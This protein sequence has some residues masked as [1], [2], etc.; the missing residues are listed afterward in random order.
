M[1]LPNFETAR[2]VLR[3]RA[4]AD[5]EACLAMDRE[6]GVTRFVVGPWH[7][8]LA[9]RALIERRTLGP[10]GDGLGYWVIAPRDEP[11]GFLGWV[12]L[13]AEDAIGPEVE[14]GWRLRR[15]AWG[16]GFAT[17]AARPV[18]AHGINSVGLVRVIADI[19]PGNAASRRV[20]EKLGMH[21]HGQARVAADGVRYV[22]GREEFLSP[23][24]GRSARTP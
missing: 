13:I 18:L 22:I 2:L 8:P 9:H 17:E 3:P 16:Q 20:A 1:D 5:T 11:Q 7:D 24:A 6:P 15:T 4:L 10:H 19:Q 14:I 23:D 21:E 12:L